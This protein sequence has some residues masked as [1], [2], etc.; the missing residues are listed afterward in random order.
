MTNATVNLI[1]EHG[2]RK[3]D[4][5]I[6]FAG[7]SEV[8]AEHFARRMF[9]EWGIEHRNEWLFFLVTKD[10]KR[11]RLLK[12]SALQ[13]V[14]FE[15]IEF[16]A[17]HTDRKQADWE[18]ME[19]WPHSMAAQVPSE[20]IPTGTN[21]P[22][23]ADFSYTLNCNFCEAQGCYQAIQ[24]QGFVWSGLD[25]IEH[26]FC[27]ERCRRN[28]QEKN[29]AVRCSGFLCLAHV[30]KH[31]CPYTWWANG[32]LHYFCSSACRDGFIS[33]NAL[34][35]PLPTLNIRQHAQLPVLTIRQP[36]PPAYYPSPASDLIQPT[37]QHVQPTLRGSQ[38]MPQELAAALAALFVLL[39]LLVLASALVSP[40]GLDILQQKHKNAVQAGAPPKQ[41]DDRQLAQFVERF[42]QRNSFPEAR[43]RELFAETVN[44][45]G[46]SLTRDMVLQ[47]EALFNTRWTSQLIRAE[48]P[49]ITW[50]AEGQRGTVLTVLHVTRRQPVVTIEEKVLSRLGVQ[51]QSS[52]GFRVFHVAHQDY[53][54]S[55][56]QWNQAEQKRRVQVA[57]E[58]YF[59]AAQ[60]QEDQSPWYAEKVHLFGKKDRSRDMIRSE[61][62]DHDRKFLVTYEFKQPAQ[63]SGLGTSTVVADLLFAVQTQVRQGVSLASSGPSK[64]LRRNKI[65][66]IFDPEDKYMAK[67]SKIELATP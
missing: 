32:Q 49:Q 9:R 12:N 46:Q 18:I 55:E 58:G 7:E 33:R 61:Q 35:S 43:K 30:R 28:Y 29:E 1:G 65:H 60:R 25:F 31:G 5:S 11:Y 57:L 54:G 42:F 20:K 37:T 44:Y 64:S 53:Q 40:N 38:V 8:S 36:S 6:I 45:F 23:F 66:F 52:D 15:E 26:R 62:M 56:Y 41:R 48:K 63:V 47:K 16:L 21:T 67:I 24:G 59:R 10:E 39:T 4:P 14:H 34:S 3:I 22:T 27:S 51:A 2:T 50:D 13:S 19:I 17:W